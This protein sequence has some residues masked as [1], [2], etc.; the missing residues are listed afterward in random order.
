[1][2]VTGSAPT[3]TRKTAANR[4]KKRK[5]VLNQKDGFLIHTN[6]CFKGG[7]S[8]EKYTQPAVMHWN[9]A[10]A[11]LEKIGIDMT[12]HH[13]SPRFHQQQYTNQIKTVMVEKVDSEESKAFKMD[14]F[15]KKGTLNQNPQDYNF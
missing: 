3:Q 11:C 6:Q 8:P 13:K 7:Y 15:D 2:P 9:D 5:N 10:I 4:S 12:A 14:F 1:M